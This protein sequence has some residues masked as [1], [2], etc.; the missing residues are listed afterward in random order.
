[1]PEEDEGHKGGKYLDPVQEERW[2]KEVDNKIER[3]RQNWARDWV[4]NQAPVHTPPSSTRSAPKGSPSPSIGSRASIASS[5][6]SQRLRALQQQRQ[7][8]TGSNT[9]DRDRHSLSGGGG[10]DDQYDRS[11][12]R[13]SIKTTSSRASSQALRHASEAQA[14]LD[15]TRPG[16]RAPFS[17][18]EKSPRLGTSFSRFAGFFSPS[19]TEM[20]RKCD[21]DQQLD[22]ELTERLHHEAKY[23]RGHRKKKDWMKVY[24]DESVKFAAVTRQGVKP[25]AP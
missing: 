12:S 4:D 18:T 9:S 23:E 8:A 3:V 19:Y 1:M 14:A 11:S 10:G 24:Q 5:T 22:E 15:A 13:A 25:S 16:P 6:S 21:E 7:A 2:M 20:K 17:P